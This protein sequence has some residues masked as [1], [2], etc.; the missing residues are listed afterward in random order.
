MG[1]PS[2]GLTMVEEAQRRALS[3]EWPFLG[4]YLIYRG[5]EGD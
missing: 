3:E 5:H 4:T 1:F 2:L